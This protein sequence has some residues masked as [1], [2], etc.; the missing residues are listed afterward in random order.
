[1]CDQAGK[2]ND[3]ACVRAG[4]FHPNREG[5][6]AYYAAISKELGKI[7]RFTVWSQN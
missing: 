3:I 6:Q 4:T 5:A 1:M 2:G 7:W